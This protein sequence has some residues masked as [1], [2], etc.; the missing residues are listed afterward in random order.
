MD[1]PELLLPGW[2]YAVMVWA[3][4]ICLGAS[5]VGIVAVLIRENK[6]GEVW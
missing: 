3:A 6:R 2:I 4:I 1:N 5:V